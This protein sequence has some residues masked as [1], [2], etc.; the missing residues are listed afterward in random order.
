MY[1]P[2]KPARPSLTYLVAL[3]LAALVLI[4]LGLL[5]VPARASTTSETS[6]AA[7]LLPCLTKSAATTKFPSRHL[8]YRT[9]TAG[10]K[11]WTGGKPGKREAYAVRVSERS[12]LSIDRKAPQ[13]RQEARPAPPAEAAPTYT[14]MVEDAYLA[15][16]GRPCPFLMPFDNRWR[17]K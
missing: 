7:A 14:E 15:L 9:N 1:N 2:L 12:I 17:I 6:K 8:Y 5:P 3:I 10:Q 11:C 4:A 13:P 16:C